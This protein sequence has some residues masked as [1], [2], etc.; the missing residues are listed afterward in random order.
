MLDDPA[1]RKDLQNVLRELQPDLN[2]IS[3]GPLSDMRRGE[4]AQIL[5]NMSADSNFST[6][7]NNLVRVADK[8]INKANNRIDPQE[9]STGLVSTTDQETGRVTYANT[10]VGRAAQAAD[11]A[12]DLA[13]SGYTP[14]ANAPVPA[15]APV[16][17]QRQALMA[18]V[19]RATQMQSRAFHDTM[20]PAGRQAAEAA[21]QASRQS[22]LNRME[23]DRRLHAGEPIG[24]PLGFTDSKPLPPRQDP[25]PASMAFAAREL[26]NRREQLPTA[27]QAYAPPTV[28]SPTPIPPR[29]ADVTQME[30]RYDPKTGAVTAEVPHTM[31]GETDSGAL[32]QYNAQAAAA[33]KQQAALDAYNASVRNMN[34]PGAGSTP[35]QQLK[36][37]E[38]QQKA[39][40]AVM[41]AAS[42]QEQQNFLNYREKIKQGQAPTP[43]EEETAVLL[44]HR[45]NKQLSGADGGQ[46]APQQP[47]RVSSPED[48]RR[49]PSGT[50]FM[51]PDG[52]VRVRN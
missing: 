52:E 36:M 22:D 3:L 1:V 21:R 48:A 28:T 40:A 19:D 49:L 16:D 47:V 42:K 50:Q 46:A 23:I 14:Y 24:V 39:Q 20:A 12:A 30:R 35:A 37:Q 38:L 32:A 51:L 33:T 18:P 6:S 2:G 8:L 31:R 5:P 13:R 25:T 43:Q 41:N 29:G 7:R 34:F 4:T 9:P 27:L 17:A 11:Q 10:A 26:A 44:T 15:P 45:I